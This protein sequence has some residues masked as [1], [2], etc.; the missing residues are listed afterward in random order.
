MCRP[1][2]VDEISKLQPPCPKKRVCAEKL[3]PLSYQIDI[4]VGEIPFGTQHSVYVLQ[5]RKYAPKDNESECVSMY[6]VQHSTVPGIGR[7][8]MERQL[9]GQDFAVTALAEDLVLV[10]LSHY[11]YQVHSATLL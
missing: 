4:L 6:A 1:I 2:Y 10:P 11:K 5:Q 3:K 8:A 7:E 9:H